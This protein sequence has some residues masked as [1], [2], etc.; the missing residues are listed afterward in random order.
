MP[1]ATIA[2][3]FDLAIQ[4]ENYMESLYTALAQKFIITPPVADFWCR[5]AEQ[6][7]M[8]ALQL[9]VIRESLTPDELLATT[10]SS[11]EGYARLLAVPIEEKLKAVQDL[12]AA[13]AL[14]VD[15]ETPETNALFSFLIKNF[16]HNAEVE[17]LL[18]ES[19]QQHIEQLADFARFFGVGQ[20]RRRIRTR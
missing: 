15:L 2:E 20:N 18:L 11:F 13:F 7:R 19:L 8:H 17:T 1:D 4:V 10:S 16:A 9:E 3:H 6:E 14:A 12:D 5:L